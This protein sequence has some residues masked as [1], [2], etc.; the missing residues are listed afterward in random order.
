MLSLSMSN[1][2]LS[3]V[4]LLLT[5]TLIIQVSCQKEDNCDPDLCP[6]M[7]ICTENGCGCKYDNMV[8]AGSL[9]VY[10]EIHSYIAASDAGGLLPENFYFAFIGNSDTIQ[11]P[12]GQYFQNE[13]EYNAPEYN[14]KG[15][16][17][18]TY[19]KAS[20]PPE[21]VLGDAFRLVMPYSA[22]PAGN[23]NGT[24]DIIINGTFVHPDTISSIVKLI[25]CVPE[26]IPEA[27]NQYRV[28]FIRIKR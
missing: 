6:G 23:G 22:Y 15:G 1:R 17:A 26:T 3:F 2:V 5:C 13:V 27:N 8:F 9:C 24:C 10:P 14:R 18:V 28:N 12:T 25:N 4:A 16:L 11:G 21:G 7:L 20:Y 19:S